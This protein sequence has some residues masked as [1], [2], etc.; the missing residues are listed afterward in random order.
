MAANANHVARFPSVWECQD[1]I[2]RPNDANI[3]TAGDAISDNATTATAAGC[4]TLDFKTPA[5]GGSIQ[6]TDFTLHKSDH[7]VTAATFWLLLFDAMP[8]VAGWEDN[9][10]LAITDAEMLTCKAV[11][12]FPAASWAN[13][14]TGDVMTVCPTQPIGIVFPAGSTTLYGILVA[15][16]AYTPSASEILTLTAHAIRR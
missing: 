2:T 12:T 1:S 15:G 8:A 11:V 13:V 10:A 9:G 5:A 4:F 14:I 6:L 16:D 3:Y 7:D